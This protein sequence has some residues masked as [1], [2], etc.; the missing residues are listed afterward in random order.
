MQIFSSVKRKYQ[1]D[2]VRS[3]M[4]HSSALSPRY[5]RP[6]KDMLHIP[7][8]QWD[9]M[10]ANAVKLIWPLWHGP[11]TKQPVEGAA[12][13]AQGAAAAPSGKH[14]GRWRCVA[15][16]SGAHLQLHVPHDAM[17]RCD[18]STMISQRYNSAICA[19]MRCR[20]MCWQRLQP[21]IRCAGCRRRGG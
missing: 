3:L 1:Q 7:Q 5:G 16:R 2:V 6:G 10:K 17:S 21:A 4:R 12:G 13:A 14:D 20:P 8:E 18:N 9:S 19:F 11:Q 15:P